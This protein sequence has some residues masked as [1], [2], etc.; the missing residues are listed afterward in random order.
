MGRS[1]FAITTVY[2]WSVRLHN[3]GTIFV[4]IYPL[5][6]VIGDFLALLAAFSLSYVLRVQID[7]DP[8][9][10]EIPALSFIKVF[11]L[12]F[13]IW[14]AVNA[15]L[16]LY[17]KPIYERRFPELGRLLVGSF[18][19]ILLIIGFDFIRDETIF[20]ARLVP[21]YGFLLAFTLLAIERNL[22][23]LLRRYL[24]RFGYGV[25]GVMIIGGNHATK[26]LAEIIKHT[27]TSG[28]RV[29]AIVSRKKLDLKVPDV[30]IFSSVNEAIDAIPRMTLHTVI[31]TEMYDSEKTNSKIFEAI[32]NHHLQYKF[33]PAQSEFYTGKN[34]V[35]LLYGFPV[36]AVH[37]TPLLGWG[38][39]IKRVLD[40][41]ASLIVLIPALPVMAI[42]AIIIK[43]NDPAGPVIFK[44]VRYTRFGTKFNV[45]KLRSMY[46]KY[47]SSTGSGKKS[48]ADQFREM[49]REDLA[50]EYEK[51]FK[52]R[53]DPRIMPIGNFIRT[54][55]ID[56]LPQLFNVI[57]GDLSL[58]GPRAMLGNE[59]SLYRKAASGDVVLSV[60][61][62]IT[63]LWQVSGRSDLSYEERLRLDLYYVQN[64]SLWI[65]IKILFKTIA[66]VLTRAGAR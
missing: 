9:I 12:L 16:G 41:I 46:W 60:K 14:L 30:E 3:S 55:S 8:L 23:W 25:R 53:E 58:V 22:L 65:D 4:M 40:V 63:G 34:N 57:K 21:V 32:R 11:L 45:Y 17:S 7:T 39:V 48:A 37:Q 42:F 31:Q 36:I 50:E 19:G 61:S 20:P 38:R 18:L 28:Y 15:L 56:E 33:I 24:F 47:S 49:G 29:T 27:Q 52:V 62:G 6:L 51:H 35:E 43:I 64:W 13:P 5:I 10:R 26:S 59:M 44:Q 2:Y 66:V 1:L 54:S